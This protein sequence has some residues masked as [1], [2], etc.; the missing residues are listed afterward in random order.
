P[1]RPCHSHPTR[2][3]NRRTR[4]TTATNASREHDLSNEDDAVVRERS[5]RPLGPDVGADGPTAQPVTVHTS[6]SAISPPGAPS[7]G[8]PDASA[9]GGA[10]DA[11]AVG[12]LLDGR[13]RDLRR[14]ARDLA[15]EPEFRRLPDQSVAEHRERVLAQLHRLVE[16]GDV[17]R[18]FP[19]EVGGRDDPGG[20]LAGFEELFLADPSLQIKGGVQWGLFGSAVQH[21]GVPEQHRRWLPDIM[22]LEVPGCFAMTEVGHGSDVASIATTATYDPAS[23]E[24]VLHTPF[25]AATKEFIG[26]A[27]VHGTA[28]I[29]FAQLH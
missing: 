9:E 25:P 23:E 29:V 16:R 27:A 11:R 19:A 21:L 13:W 14:A 1:P 6:T 10:I 22:S 8:T 18:A 24:F 12:D 15:L 17:N 26:N 28:A 2:R 3:R 4:M 5:G 20:N 7:A